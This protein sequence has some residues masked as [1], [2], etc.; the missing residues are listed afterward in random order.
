MKK[1]KKKTRSK[2]IAASIAI[3]SSAA[4]VSTGF[5]AWVISGGDTETANGTIKADQ[6][7]NENHLI[8]GLSKD[9]QSIVFGGPSAE[10][11]NKNQSLVAVNSRWLTNEE[12]TEKLSAEWTFN[13]S[14][15][16]S[17]AAGKET[18]LFDIAFKEDDPVGKGDASFAN[19]VTNKYVSNLPEWGKSFVTEAGT[20]SG[21]YLVAGRYDS[22][23]KKMSYTLTVVFAW[24]EIFGNMNPYFYYNSSTAQRNDKD[25]A[26][27]YLSALAKM[28]TS[29]TLTIKT[30]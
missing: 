13:V 20:A 22:T 29:F 28:D 18:K 21:I 25:S 4:V 14:G 23:S 11:I 16:Q 7:S 12:H 9:A 3:L 10:D 19:A 24:G 17:E 2:M 5:A 30:N 6:V 8:D 15:L 26:N 27:T 1:F